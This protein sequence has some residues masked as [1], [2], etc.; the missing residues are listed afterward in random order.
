MERKKEAI[1]KWLPLV[2]V[3]S[4]VSLVILILIKVPLERAIIATGLL[5]LLIFS[6]FIFRSFGREKDRYDKDKIE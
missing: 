1:K 2:A 3:A 6:G 4:T 5:V